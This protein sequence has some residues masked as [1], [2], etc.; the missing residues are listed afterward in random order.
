MTTDADQAEQ[1][2]IEI[3]NRLTDRIADIGEAL[4]VPRLVREQAQAFTFDPRAVT[5]RARSQPLP[6]LLIGAGLVASVLTPERIAGT[7][8]GR[9]S[10]IAG[11][12]T[13]DGAGPERAPTAELAGFAGNHHD[14]D[15]SGD[16]MERMSGAARRAGSG[17]RRVDR[18][19]H[20]SPL[21][22]IAVAAAV[23]ALAGVW[24]GRRRNRD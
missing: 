10:H 20:R 5:D 22:T 9:A 15:A 2:V 18:A 1:D 19:A 16:L 11:P 8:N 6:W 7:F 3:R 14:A 23:G 17:A 13:R 4:S 21:T 24:L 12:R